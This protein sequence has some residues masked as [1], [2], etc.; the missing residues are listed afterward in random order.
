M[1]SLRKLLRVALDA[2]FEAFLKTSWS[3]DFRFWFLPRVKTQSLKSLVLVVLVEK[4]EENKFF[5]ELIH[6]GINQLCFQ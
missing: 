5:K 2:M 1:F 4:Q 6:M 3:S